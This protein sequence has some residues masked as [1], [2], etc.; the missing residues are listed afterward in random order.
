MILPLLSKKQVEIYLFDRDNAPKITILEG[1]VRSGKSYINNILWIKHV[2]RFRNRGVKFIMTGST[3]ASLKRNVLD[4]LE[5][6]F[7]INTFLNQNNEFRMF[8]N[9]VACFGSDSANA[10]K[11]LKGFTAYGWYA[12]E[13]TEHHIN[14]VDQAF[15]RCSGEGARIFW[16]TNPGPPNHHIKA[17]YIDH[18]GE[19]LASG[20]ML[21]KSWHFVLDDNE[22]LEKEYIESL[23]RA[24]PT[25]MWY[26]RDILGLW[27]AAEGMIYKDFDLS[28]HVVDKAPESMKEYFAGVDWGYDHHGVMG[29]YG[30]DNDG[31]KYRLF[32]VA[33]RER[34]IE[35]WIKEARAV[36]E[37]HGNIPFYCDPSEPGFIASFQKAGLNAM[38]ADNNVIP[39]ISYVA[40]CFKKNEFFIVRDRNKLFLSEIYNYRWRQSGTDEA[41]I[42]EDDDAMDETR[43]ALFTHSVKSGRVIRPSNVSLGRLGL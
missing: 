37:K 30:V 14:T 28:K 42:K 6:I 35:Y 19:R 34:G 16:D 36:K 40:S 8:G 21:V 23:K 41:P 33:E 20:K 3:I 2:L 26:D 38:R 1:A 17:N 43:Y 7:G 12:N 25:G 11:P 4:D 18:D 24:T 9:S 15:K 32:E 27:V 13:V 39:G 31:R 29:V 10:Y 5:G 22:Y